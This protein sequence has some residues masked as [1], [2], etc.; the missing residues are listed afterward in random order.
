[1]IKIV[2]KISVGRVIVI[3]IQIAF[4]IFNVALAVDMLNGH[5]HYRI[6]GIIMM[7]AVVSAAL[8]FIIDASLERKERIANAKSV[9]ISRVG[10]ENLKKCLSYEEDLLARAEKDPIGSKQELAEYITFIF[11][12]MGAV[13]LD[14]K[15]V[16]TIMGVDWLMRN[17]RTCISITQQDIIRVDLGY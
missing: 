16:R 17:L 13:D 5:Y 3:I 8:L 7:I 14:A 4:V 1:M 15:Q 12:D 10:L 2:E 9:R 6:L 11:Q